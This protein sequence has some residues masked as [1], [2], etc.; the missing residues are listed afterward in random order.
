MRQINHDDSI[1]ILHVADLHIGS[2]MAVGKRVGRDKD[3]T[4]ATWL[5]LENVIDLA[6]EK[7]VDVVSI[8]GDVFDKIDQN[9]PLPRTKLI[10]SLSKLGEIPVAL[11]RGNHDHLS[12]SVPLIPWPDNVKE[13]TKSDPTL[14]LGRLCIHGIS[15]DREKQ[16]DNLVP[17][18]PDLIDGRI[19]IGLLHANVG[20]Q[21]G[22]D[23]YSPT[24]IATLTAKGYQA[25]LLGHIHQR[26]VLAEN[27]LI[28]Y[29]GNI[30]GRHSGEMG[31]RTVEIVTVM[32]GEIAITEPHRVHAV[33]W[34]QIIID[35]SQV[36]DE[37]EML[38]LIDKMI[39]DKISELKSERGLIL[40]LRMTG[41]SPMHEKLSSTRYSK[42]HSKITDIIQE[43]VHESRGY[44]KDDPFILIDKVHVN[45]T[46]P[47]D[48]EV[49][50]K[51]DDNVLGVVA[52]MLN[53]DTL[54][55]EAIDK[56]IAMGIVDEKLLIE[57]G[58]DMWEQAVHSALGRI[59]G[60]TD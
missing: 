56:L 14:D 29:P 54:L 2:A 24:D 52:R 49:L 32:E 33:L 41:P 34:D 40:R 48:I 60:R 44:A 42:D 47:Y 21:R 45:T 38:S 12:R 36:D 10:R 26:Q 51:L 50:S 18:Y 55:S 43:H 22:H 27:P 35:L 19:N 28:I 57:N 20:G 30:Q 15:Y 39:D 23:P 6:L 59:R 37:D 7:N 25:W 8:G 3:L 4:A 16:K 31:P 13:L 5:A 1:K 53:D 17:Q 58:K 11:V 46:L 9:N